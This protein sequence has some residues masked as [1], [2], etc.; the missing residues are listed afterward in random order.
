MYI[1]RSLSLSNTLVE[2]TMTYFENIIVQAYRHNQSSSD[3]LVRTPTIVYENYDDSYVQYTEKTIR[4]PVL[5]L[6]L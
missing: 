4:D 2:C 3:F 1:I 5:V 6:R